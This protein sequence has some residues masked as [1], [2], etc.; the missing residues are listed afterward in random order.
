MLNYIF[1]QLTNNLFE[2]TLC[3]GLSQLEIRLEKTKNH[4]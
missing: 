4:S 2:M 3:S 1:I